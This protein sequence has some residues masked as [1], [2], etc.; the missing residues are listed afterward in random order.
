MC[1]LK[2][3]ELSLGAVSFLS[4]EKF[5]WTDKYLARGFKCQVEV[6]VDVL[7]ISFC[8]H[9]SFHQVLVSLGGVLC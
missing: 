4:Q 9:S 6:V 8:Q 7:N 2:M 5:K 1:Y 3:I